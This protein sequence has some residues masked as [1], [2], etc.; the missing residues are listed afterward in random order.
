MTSSDTVQEEAVSRVHLVFKTHLDV[1]FTDLGKAVLQRYLSDYIPA[2]IRVAQSSTDEARFVWTTGSWLIWEFLE[3][4]STAERRSMEEAI[5]AGSVVWHALPFTMHSELLDADLLRDGLRMSRQLDDR[6]GRRTV[7]AKMTDVPGHTRGI[8]GPLAD[9]GVE[10]L[11]IGVNPASSLPKVPPAFRWREPAGRELSVIYQEH[12]GDFSVLPGSPVALAFAHTGDNH[13]P[14]SGEQVVQAYERITQLAPGAQIIG[15][16]LNAFAEDIRPWIKE[17]PVVTDEIGDTWIHGVGSDPQLVARYR[18][19]LR[20]NAEWKREAAPDVP[21]AFTENLLLVAEHT[22]GLDHKSTLRDLNRGYD[23][24]EFARL[25]GDADYQ[26]MEISWREKRELVDDAVAA[27]DA[28]PSRAGQARQ[29]LHD[30]VPTKETPAAAALSGGWAADPLGLS[31]DGVQV[32]IDGAVGDLVELRDE[33]RSWASENCRLA[34]LG[35]EIFSAADYG[36][37][38]R[39]Y[40]RDTDRNGWWAIRDFT[41]PGLD[42][43]GMDHTAWLPQV[44]DVQLTSSL[45]RRVLL[46]FPDEAVNRFGCPELFTVDYRL[47]GRTLGIDVQ[48]FD[49]PAT[50]Y[51]EA[52]WLSFQ[53]QLPAAGVNSWWLDK[54]GQRVSTLEVV[55]HGG[56]HLHAVNEGFGY[57]TAF[58]VD[59]LDACLVCP[60]R[61]ELVHFSDEQPAAEDGMHVNLYNNTWG[62]NFPGWSQGDA[63]FRFAIRL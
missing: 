32:R 5:E 60:G 8:V 45:S 23:R 47:T 7:A 46:R 63:L 43:L 58:Q 62:T 29:A 2:A 33:E 42:A 51:P 15:S 41:K 21:S 6:F 24:E 48:W 17:L 49:K 27:L 37:F 26:R 56:R 3:H 30:L 1:G 19:L 55:P 10:F 12:Y 52:L 14:Q 34:S 35:Y 38:Y 40:N 31:A 11:H 61:R 54:L 25:R 57:D 20:L 28:D 53:P 4:G 13:G 59:T 44:D 16:S 39:A 9:A 22:W 36:E 50:R 18:A